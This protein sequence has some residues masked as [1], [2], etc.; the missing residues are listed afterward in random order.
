[1][2]KYKTREAARKAALEANLLYGWS[3]L[4]GAYYKTAGT[5]KHE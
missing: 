2:G 3:V 4:S 5:L 1:M